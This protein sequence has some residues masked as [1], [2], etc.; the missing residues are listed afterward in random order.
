MFKYVG[1]KEFIEVYCKLIE[2]AKKKTTV[3]YS[4]LAPILGITSPGNYMGSEV[5]KI[6]EE[7]SII[8]V[9]NKRPMLNAVVVAKE[10]GLPGKGFFEL[11]T[12]LGKLAPQDSEKEFW[13]SEL[14]E[15]YN[16]WK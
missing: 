9:L 13:E 14:Q 8:E 12:R 5:G 16:T 6:V 1:S 3:N 4:D 15:V 2:A 7:I 11:A 10:S